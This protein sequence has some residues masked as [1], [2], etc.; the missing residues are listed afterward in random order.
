MKIKLKKKS[1]ADTHTHTHTHTHIPFKPFHI[2]VGKARDIIFCFTPTL[3][4]HF[5]YLSF[6]KKL[7]IILFVYISNVIPLP[8]LPSMNPVPFPSPLPLR[9][10][11]PTH[12]LTHSCLT[13]LASPFS[14]AAN[15]HRTKCG[16]H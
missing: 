11:S 5:L 8:G 9:G 16:P 13:P 6:L 7:L 2:H 10:C 15:L 3:C 4:V 12:P 1:I 14:G